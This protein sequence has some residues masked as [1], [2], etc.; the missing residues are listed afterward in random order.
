MKTGVRADARLASLNK[1]PVNIPKLLPTKEQAVSRSTKIDSKKH[2][3]FE[4]L[5]KGDGRS[6]K[7]EHANTINYSANNNRPC[8]DYDL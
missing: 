6:N 4:K 3:E 2:T 1:D 5:Y 7:K 8:L